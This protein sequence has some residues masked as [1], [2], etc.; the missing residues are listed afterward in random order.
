MQAPNTLDELYEVL[1]A[2]KE[3]DANGNGCLLYTSRVRL[4][5][6]WKGHVVLCGLSPNLNKMV[7][8]S[9]IGSVASIERRAG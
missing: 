8:L 4:Y 5:N 6:F 9:G 3:Q 7:E 1:K 2:F